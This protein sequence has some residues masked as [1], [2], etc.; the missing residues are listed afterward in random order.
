[1]V[2]YVGCRVVPQSTL[3]HVCYA[4]VGG[5]YCLGGMGVSGRVVLIMLAEGGINCMLAEGGINWGPMP[6]TPL[7]DCVCACVHVCVRAC[8]RVCVVL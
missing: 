7:Q 3:W 2:V 8:V 6:C 4:R 5:V 1:M